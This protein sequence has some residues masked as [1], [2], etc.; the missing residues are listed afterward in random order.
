MAN[1]LT[2]LI[3]TIYAAWKIV[4]RELI[5]FI[6]A[7]LLNPMAENQSTADMAAVGQSIT[8][9]I[10]P[11]GVGGNIV[12][13]QLPPNDG[14]VVLGSGSMT[15]S[16]SMYGPPIR[17]NGEEEKALSVRTGLLNDVKVQ[18]FAQAFRWLT[19]QVE[20][21]VAAAAYVAASRAYGTAGTPPFG[22]ANDFGDFAGVNQILDDNGAPMIDR[23]LILNSAAIAN[24]RGKQS[25][26][27]KANE[28]GTEDLLRRGIIGQVQGLDIHQ[29]GQALG[30]VTKGTGAGYLVNNAGPYAIGTKAIAVDT[31]TGT[32]LAGD[33]I[34]FTGDSNRYV[35]TTALGGGVVTIAE[36]GL[37]QT[38]ADNV[39]LTVGANFRPSIGL[40]RNAQVLLTRQPMMPLG[41][42]S[43][44]DV[45]PFIDPL[46]GITFQIA[47][48][49]EYRQSRIEIALA[50][51]TKVTNP[52]FIAQLLG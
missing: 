1:T 39:A 26:L 30:I 10:V 28:A 32:V 20:A 5:G 33:S 48:Y 45:R 14:D 31:G 38:L 11:P 17:W 34:T 40:N 37:R 18:Q 9:P 24:I 51:G 2:G 19:N 46:T 3:P 13:G 7:V 12:P 25:I 42:D 23:H 35:V 36:P 29:S 44:T 52:E 49:G 8:Y 16:K 15:I 47:R 21:D 27:F 22:T 4:A 50:W 41:G 43:S 6:P